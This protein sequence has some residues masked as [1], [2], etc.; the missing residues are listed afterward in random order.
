MLLIG[1]INPTAVGCNNCQ[2]KNN[3]ICVSGRK[4]FHLIWQPEQNLVVDKVDLPHT[5]SFLINTV[6]CS[7]AD[8]LSGLHALN[9]N[10]VKETLLMRISTNSCIII[11]VM[12]DE[13]VTTLISQVGID[14][15]RHR[16]LSFGRWV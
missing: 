15:K 11:P 2:Y 4:K 8:V 3:K 16:L 13:A 12:R 6:V 5:S 10:E 7:R 14:R 9:N 1:K